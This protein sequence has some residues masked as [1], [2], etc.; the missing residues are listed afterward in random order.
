MPPHP[1]ALGVRRLRDII[2]KTPN[3]FR[4]AERRGLE[5]YIY[6][7]VFYVE[8]Q[9][10]VGLLKVNAAVRHIVCVLRVLTGLRRTRLAGLFVVEVHHHAHLS[11]LC[12]TL[13]AKLGI[14]EDVD[15][16]P[17]TYCI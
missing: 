4:T 12:E 7:V 15:E 11:P 14:H 9:L 3:T 1:A 2:F 17:S 10:R 8:D 13:A 6:I 5:H 16:L